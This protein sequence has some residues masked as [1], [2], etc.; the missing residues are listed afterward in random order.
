MG[1]RRRFICRYIRY[2]RIPRRD[3]RIIGT[4][5][6][7]HPKSG[8]RRRISLCGNSLPRHRTPPPSREYGAENV[9]RLGTLR[10][11]NAYFWKSKLVG[12][13]Y[14]KIKIKFLRWIL[15]P[16]ICSPS[17]VQE[18]LLRS[19]NGPNCFKSSHLANQAL[20]NQI[21][22]LN[23]RKTKRELI[24]LASFSRTRVEL[25]RPK[26]WETFHRQTCNR[27]FKRK[28]HVSTHK[29]QKAK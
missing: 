22:F 7:F 5:L 21:H 20:A 17:L 4:N 29:P 8:A 23:L 3:K 24:I 14:Y 12:S 15:L 28:Q 19:S 9:N 25:W 26:L 2:H 18:K 1:K 13:G 10:H 16:N 27:Q 11:N 6:R